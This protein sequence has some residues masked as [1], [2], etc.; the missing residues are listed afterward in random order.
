LGVVEIEK[1]ICGLEILD[2]VEEVLGISDKKWK[3]DLDEESW[4]FG[5]RKMR[6]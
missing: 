3:E 6:I 4:E 2:F 5:G 1:R